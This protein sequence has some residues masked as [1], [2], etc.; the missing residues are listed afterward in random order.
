MKITFAFLLILVVRLSGWPQTTDPRSQGSATQGSSSSDTSNTREAPTTLLYNPLN[1]QTSERISMALPKVEKA[2]TNL[3]AK[4]L[5]VSSE[6]HAAVEFMGEFYTRKGKAPDR[7][8]YTLESM[9][10]LLTKAS[11][12]PNS[13]QTQALVRD[14]QENLQ[15]M[16]ES[17]EPTLATPSAETHRIIV[18]TEKG[19]KEVSGWEIF[20]M[21]YFFVHVKD[22]VGP[23]SFPRPSS[24][25]EAQ[26][27]PSRYVIQAVNTVTG[28]KSE[29][30]IITVHNQSDEFVIQVK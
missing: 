16:Y 19:N 30:K 6:S 3:D 23:D 7:Y 5:H 24:P 29:R 25:T 4:G 26:L 27:P 13:P 10:E 14:I 18:K 1:T 28:A 15:L 20:Y 2:L 17:S 12:K 22:E 9:A 21:E 8:A 11:E